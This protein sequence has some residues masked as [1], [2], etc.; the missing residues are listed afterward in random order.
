[1]NNDSIGSGNTAD[2]TKLK[3]GNNILDKWGCSEA[4]KKAIMG[5]TE[6]A[7]ARF[8]NAEGDIALDEEHVIRLGCIVNIH[9]AL[10]TLFSN[11]N[12]VYGFMQMKN[13]A[14]YFNGRTPL[15]IISA[16]ELQAL[17]KVMQQIQA[18]LE[19]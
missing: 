1:M 16:G 15:S 19:L 3:V 12:N 4:Q 7:L 10:R 17:I 5:L 13:N 2:F 11:Q 6:D 18:Q 14:P 8:L 9:E